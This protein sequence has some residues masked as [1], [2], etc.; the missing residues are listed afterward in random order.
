MFLDFAAMHL[1]A[2]L[3]YKRSTMI[4]NGHSD[5]SYLNY[6]HAWS[7]S[8]A[9][10]FMSGDSTYDIC[11]HTGRVITVSGMLKHVV[12]SAAEAQ[13]GSLFI[14]YKE[15]TICRNKLHDMG[16]PQPPTL[17]TTDNT[18][19]SG[20]LNRTVKQKRTRSMNVRFCWVADRFG[21]WQF[22]IQWEPCKGNQS[23]Y[24]NKSHSPKHNP[25]M[26]DMHLVGEGKPK[27]LP[28]FKP[29]SL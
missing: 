2:K 20:I 3:R 11:M 27:Y 4:L 15:G 17:I 19:S 1:D 28:S 16:H 9:H 26:R 23:E 25:N 8:A 13:T 6:P 7:R 24:F 10:V 14:T 22:D 29:S 12:S 21:Q 5:A 18:I